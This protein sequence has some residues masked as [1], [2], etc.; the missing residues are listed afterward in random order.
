MGLPRAAWYEARQ[1]LQKLLSKDEP[2]LRDEHVLREKAFVKQSEA[3]M[4][5]PAEI[6]IL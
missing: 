6:G 1:T 2:T 3:I 5:L 4:H